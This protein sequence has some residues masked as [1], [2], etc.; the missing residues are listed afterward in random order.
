MALVLSVFVVI[1]LV[2]VLSVTLTS[3]TPSVRTV[4]ATP[5]V[6]L[7][8]RSFNETY[9]SPPTSTT[10]I[11][12]LM[13]RTSHNKYTSMIE[14]LYEVIKTTKEKHPDYTIVYFEDDD[15]VDF[16][17]QNYPEHLPGYTSLIP[18]A[19]KA[20]IFRLLFLYTYGGFYNDCSQAYYVSCE[21]FVDFNMHKVVLVNDRFDEG[22]YNA[23]IA[24]T[25]KHPLI[26]HMIDTIMVSVNKK[27]YGRGPLDITGPNACMRAFNTYYHMPQSFRLSGTH[28]YPDASIKILHHVSYDGGV[29]VDTN[30]HKIIKNKFPNYQR[31]MY[32]NVKKIHYGDLWHKNNIY[33]V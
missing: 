2:I 12:K 31:L 3:S 26:K 23:F 16:I 7:S 33:N 11:P 28:F 21:E 4:S 30:I 20:D 13:V 29:I 1:I 9:T 10:Q 17:T 18:G 15:C 22:I 19:F 6:V 27:D 5:D 24:S 14:P 32:T 25:A 8:Y